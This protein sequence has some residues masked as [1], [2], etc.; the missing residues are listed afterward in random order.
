MRDFNQVLEYGRVGA[1]T[2][3][4]SIFFQLSTKILTLKRLPQD[5]ICEVIL[6]RYIKHNTDCVVKS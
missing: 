4:I 5:R 1:W 3:S 2:D 6:N